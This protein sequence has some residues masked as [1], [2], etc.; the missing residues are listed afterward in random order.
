[1]LFVVLHRLIE[2][3]GI[4]NTLFPPQPHFNGTFTYPIHFYKAPVPNARSRTIPRHGNTLL[5]Q[6]L[7]D[8]MKIQPCDTDF[9]HSRDAIIQADENLTG[10]ENMCDIWKAF[11]SRGLGSFAH[12]KLVGPWKDKKERTNDFSLPVKWGGTG[13]PDDG[14]NV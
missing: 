5:L 4:S 12:Y 8:T 9:F 7:V 11:A 10:G 1:M 13:K 14:H 3:H 2:K 6:L